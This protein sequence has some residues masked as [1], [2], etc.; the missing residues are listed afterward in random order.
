MALIPY[1]KRQRIAKQALA[2]IDFARQA[3][4][5]KFTQWHKNEDL[6][7]NKKI[8]VEIGKINVNL[9]EMKSFVDTFVSKINVPYNFTFVKGEEADLEKAK[10]VNAIKDKDRKAGD[11]DTKL[12][13]A[14]T[15]LV[16][17]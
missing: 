4:M 6:Y 8:I 12:L 15:Q 7:Y 2:E 13:Y 5:P 3:K 11:W 10:I 16:L 14:R 17:Y 1:E 9:N